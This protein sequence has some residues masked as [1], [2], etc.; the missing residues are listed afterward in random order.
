MLKFNFTYSVLTVQNSEALH[1]VEN[2][3]SKRNSQKYKE[4]KTDD[5]NDNFFETNLR[6]LKDNKIF[7]KIYNFSPN[8]P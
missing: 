7:I 4:S 3:P 1:I 5:N 6:L 2:N 8:K